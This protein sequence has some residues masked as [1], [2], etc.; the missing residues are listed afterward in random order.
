MQIYK[1]RTR[2]GSLH[3][4]ILAAGALTNVVHARPPRLHGVSAT[5]LAVGIDRSL[6]ISRNCD[7]QFTA[8]ITVTSSRS[9]RGFCCWRLCRWLLCCWLS[10]CAVPR[11]V[12]GS[13]LRRLCR[14]HGSFR[15]GCLRG[16]GLCGGRFRCRSLR[17][18]GLRRR[19][20]RCHSLGGRHRCLGSRFRSLRLV[21]AVAQIFHVA[22]PP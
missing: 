9:R 22:R 12:F 5:W 19:S 17:G 1:Y 14:G 18:G 7:A 16:W 15:S 10:V 13:G 8:S 20:F 11:R 2:L 6:V 4:E 21:R 3:K